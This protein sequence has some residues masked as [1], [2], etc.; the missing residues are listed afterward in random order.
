MC[1]SFSV[2]A[3]GRA[4]SMPCINVRCMYVVFREFLFQGAMFGY[5]CSTQQYSTTGTRNSTVSFSCFCCPSICRRASLLTHGRPSRSSS[6]N[7]QQS[8]QS[9]QS[10]TTTAARSSHRSAT[11][12][13]S[14]TVKQPSMGP[15]VCAVRR[16]RCSLTARRSAT[17]L[18]CAQQQSA[19]WMC[20]WSHGM[21]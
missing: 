21:G 6:S 17:S 19:V 18:P 8:A 15:R 10:S 1:Q 14:S 20:A 5:G 3:C 4:C 7:P 2:L 16:E 11:R 12:T 9:P 13:P